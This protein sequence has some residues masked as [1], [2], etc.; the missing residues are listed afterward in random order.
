MILPGEATEIG[1]ADHA[2]HLLQCRHDDPALDFRKFHQVFGIRFQRVTVDFAGRAS[3]RQKGRLDAGGQ[4]DLADVLYDALA[5]PVV[6]GAVAE[7][8]RDDGETERAARAHVHQSGS[9]GQRPL[10]WN[11]DLLLD[12]F[13][14]QPR[15]LRDHLRGDVADVRI[16][17]YRHLSPGVVAEN[18]K[19]DRHH[20]YDEPF[21]EADADDCINH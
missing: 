11:G 21:A 3:H 5:L 12:F 9:T 15:R 6:I 19:Q 8:Y 2:G 20:Y 14:G 1:D 18:G 13:G 4:A 10:Q 17:L 16:C 7:D